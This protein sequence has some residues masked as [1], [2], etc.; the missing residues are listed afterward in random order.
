MNTWN[1]LVRYLSIENS[2]FEFR[3]K[4]ESHGMKIEYI[5]LLI[6]RAFIKNKV[7]VILGDLFTNRQS[8][9]RA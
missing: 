7:L 2:V 3:A 6:G 8:N 9:A 4:M 5:A 1:L